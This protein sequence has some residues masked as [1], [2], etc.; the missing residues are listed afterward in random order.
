MAE[1][2]QIKE[3]V[4]KKLIPGRALNSHK[5]DNGKV[6]IVG[7]SLDYHGAP[8]LSALGSLRASAD[9]VYLYV[10]ECNF[11]ATRGMYPDFIVKKYAGEY[12]TERAA[13]QIIEFGKDCDSIL[14]GPGLGDNEKTIDGV[15]SL[16]ENLNIPTVLDASAISALKRVE[17]FPLKQNVVI[18]PHLHE[19][20]E[21]IDRDI[22]I[23]E[24]DT[25][26]IIL[27]RSVSM[28]LHISVLL[29]GQTDLISSFEGAV[30]LN[31]TG[32][33]GMTVGGTGDVL[34]G[35]VA[36]FLAQGADPYDAARAAAFYVG[37]AGDFL[38]KRQGYGFSAS[39]LAQALPYVLQ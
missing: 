26:S 12:L 31:K 16:L 27:L 11:E 17:R 9:L 18:T 30:E 13:E 32:N 23:S 20:Q 1:L 10:P 22:E 4:A 38:K 5:G 7:G 33:P 24:N 35:V 37:K 3:S 19:F 34:A 36:T 25:K 29:K 39:E 14:I 6:L 8:I 15:L 21:L 2:K 28:D